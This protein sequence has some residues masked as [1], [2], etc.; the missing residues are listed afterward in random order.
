MPNLPAR[1]AGRGHLVTL[2]QPLGN[3]YGS[4]EPNLTDAA[5]YWNDRCT[6]DIQKGPTLLVPKRMDVGTGF[7]TFVQSN[8]QWHLVSEH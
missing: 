8:G 7:F 5:S 4:A 6:K 3:S 1:G 2:S